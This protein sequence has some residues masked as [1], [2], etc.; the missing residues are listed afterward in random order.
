MK[1]EYFNKKKLQLG[2]KVV[3]LLS[4]ETL[5]LKHGGFMPTADTC[6]SQCAQASCKQDPNCAPKTPSYDNAS[7][8]CHRKTI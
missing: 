4:S 7:C 8:D 1:K 5:Y 2:K 3:L 6:K